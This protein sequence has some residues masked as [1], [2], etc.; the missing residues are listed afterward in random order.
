MSRKKLPT[1]REVKDVLGQVE[2]YGLLVE[3]HDNWGDERFPWRLRD[4]PDADGN[5]E[6]L[7]EFPRYSEACKAARQLWRK[8]CGFTGLERPCETT[9]RK[10]RKVDTW[11]RGGGR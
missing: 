2:V 11:G 7:D 9:P 5:R 3:H 6:I 1:A 10:P 4:V 8:R